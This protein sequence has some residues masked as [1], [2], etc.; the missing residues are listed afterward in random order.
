MAEGAGGEATAST[1]CHWEGAQV[2]EAGHI[3]A[4]LSQLRAAYNRQMHWHLKHNC[5]ARDHGGQGQQ[6]E[7]D[8]RE[9]HGGHQGVAEMGH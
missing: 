4:L 9:E 3:Y 1:G 6:Q 5:M 2:Q 8:A 7:E